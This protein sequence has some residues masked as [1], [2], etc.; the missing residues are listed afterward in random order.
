MT[1]NKKQKAN[2]PRIS[3]F[4]RHESHCKICVHPQREEIEA[5]FII[6]KSTV[7]IAA[8]FNLGDRSCI[9]RHAH[10][11]DLF[12]RRDPNL[13]LPLGRFIERADEVKLTAGSVV[14][15]ITLYQRLI[16]RGESA[17]RDDQTDL[18]YLFS[19]MSPAEMEAYAIDGTVPD[20]FTR[21][22]GKMGPQ[23]SGGNGNA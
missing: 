23:G 16:A 11:V 2:L 7:Q 10:A 17:S 8:D 9:Y 4:N 1:G 18:D 15:A 5:A 6:W 3:N 22:A 20:W 14:Q 21:L 12:S 19:K 13:L